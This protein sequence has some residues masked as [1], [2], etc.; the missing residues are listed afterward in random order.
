M[1]GKNLMIYFGSEPIP[2]STSLRTA[3]GSHPIPLLWLPPWRKITGSMRY[4][5]PPSRRPRPRGGTA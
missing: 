1:A 2:C 3:S 5:S 4:T